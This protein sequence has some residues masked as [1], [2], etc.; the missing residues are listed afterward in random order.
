MRRRATILSLLSLVVALSW[1]AGSSA[2]APNN[3]A[4]SY[5]F[6]MEEPN[7]AMASNGDTIAITGE[8]EFAVHPKSASGGGEFMAM[9]AGG[10]TIAGTWTVNG[11]V[12]FQPYGCGVIPS[13]GATLPPNLCG[14]RVSLDVT[15]TALGG[16]VPGRITVFCVIGAQAPPTHDNP[17][18]AG[19]E[20]VTVVVPGIDNFNKQVS[21]MNVYVQ[22]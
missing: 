3:Q 21:G 8:G 5:E 22:Q 20:G 13:I 10:E 17:T 6:F 1:P 14:G 19:E 11:L 4:A 2:T 12:D 15:F 16:S 18:E 9:S 7:V